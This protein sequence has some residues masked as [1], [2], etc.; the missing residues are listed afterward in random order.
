MVVSWHSA[1]PTD[2]WSR[3]IQPN[4]REWSAIGG[5]YPWTQPLIA[6]I[7]GQCS[8][9]DEWYGPF[10]TAPNTPHIVWK[11]QGAVSGIIGGEAGTY[12]ALN[13]PGT[14]DVIYMGRVYDT[15]TKH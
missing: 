9:D 14:P 5:N 2:Y 3:P 11:Q 12:S 13:N 8:W 6:G 4:N 10:V 7:D 15:D 1:L